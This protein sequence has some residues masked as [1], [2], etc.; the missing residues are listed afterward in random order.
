[1]I[2]KT[3]DLLAATRAP[4]SV[5]DHVET[6]LYG[7][8]ADFDPYV[9]YVMSRKEAYTINE[10]EALLLAQEERL[11]NIIRLIISLFLPMLMLLLR[12]L[13]VPPMA[14]LNASLVS[15]VVVMTSCMLL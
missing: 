9:A 3:V 6:I 13:C 8:S 11:P 2:K 1:M 12:P 4:V 7:L 15:L 14:N 5:E 10:I